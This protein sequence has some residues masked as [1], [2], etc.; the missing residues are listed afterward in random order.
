MRI[1]PSKKLKKLDQQK[2]KD[3]DYVQTTNS[4]QLTEDLCLKLLKG[5]SSGFS[6]PAHVESLDLSFQK[7][8]SVEKALN[9]FTGLRKL[10]L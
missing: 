6:T 10:N 3:S 4:Q 5:K 1:F 9:K 2:I 7:L 8:S